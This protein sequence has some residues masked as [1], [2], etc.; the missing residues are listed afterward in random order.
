MK[1]TGSV[2]PYKEGNMKEFSHIACPKCGVAVPESAVR[3]LRDGFPI[4]CPSCKKVFVPGGKRGRVMRWARRAIVLLLLGAAAYA[5]YR[6][7]EE[8]VAFWKY[9]TVSETAACTACAEGYVRCRQC[10]GRGENIV[11]KIVP[12]KTC[13]GTGTGPAL[14]GLQPPPCT[15]CKATPGKQTDHERF[16]CQTCNGKGRM[17][18]GSCKGTG[19][20]DVPPRWKQWRDT[21]KDTVVF[22]K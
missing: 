10:E 20:V 5:G 13:K 2:R 11:T 18:C 16:P 17:S 1:G 12:C 9:A 4:E 22:W 3:Y 8:A 21:V 15:K 7:R 14:Q 6:Y 19:S